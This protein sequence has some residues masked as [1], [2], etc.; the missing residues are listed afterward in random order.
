MIDINNKTSA[1][2]NLKLVKNIAAKFLDFYRIK[3][4]V[5]IAFVGDSEIRRLNKIYRKVNKVTDVLSFSGDGNLLGEIIIDYGQIKRQAKIY[6]GS[7]DEE[8]VYILVHGLL[9]LAGFDH[10]SDKDAEKMDRA[11]NKFLKQH[12]KWS[13]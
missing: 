9:H 4:D 5:S 10:E 2:V 7:V 12:T 6:S 3:K 13:K 11:E 1:I 8:L